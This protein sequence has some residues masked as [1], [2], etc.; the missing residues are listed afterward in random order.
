MCG[1]AWI[2]WQE[3]LKSPLHPSRVGITEPYEALEA[4]KVKICLVVANRE[5]VTQHVI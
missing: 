1:T 5:S 2:K 3:V 4:A